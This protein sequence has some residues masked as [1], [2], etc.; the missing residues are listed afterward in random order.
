[1]AQR[2]ALRWLTMAQRQA[3]EY[4]DVEFTEMFT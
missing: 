3:A 2:N 4:G 1:M